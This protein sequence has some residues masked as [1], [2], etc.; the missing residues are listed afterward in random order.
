[1]PTK[2]DVKRPRESTPTQ[3]A[4]P[5]SIIGKPVMKVDA[6]AKVVGETMFADDLS[7]PRMLFCK[8][9]RSP[10]P[11]ARIVN[12]DTSRAEAM[13][14]RPRRARRRRATHPV[15]HSPRVSGRARALHRQSA[16]RRRPVAAVA[17]IDEETAEAA[18]D[19]I[20]VDY[21][22][23]PADHDHRG[24]ARGRLGADPHGRAPP[25]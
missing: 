14:R 25:R 2:T 19:L 15:R 11:H 8:I 20:D 24:R 13:D 16:L 23:L 3:Q 7:L 5:L 10:H 4:E 6:M 22:V 9:K 17:A 12:V 1:M 18:L 21:E